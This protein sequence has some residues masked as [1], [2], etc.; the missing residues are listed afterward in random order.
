[1]PF[2]A[3]KLPSGLKI[4]HNGEVI[5]LAGANIGENL[6]NPSDNGNPQDNAR[7]AYGFGLTELN[8][9]QTAAFEDWKKKM[10]FKNGDSG[11][12]LTEPFAALENNS[13]MGPFKSRDEAVKE[14]ADLHT[15]VRTGTEGLDPEKEKDIEDAVDDGEKAPRVQR[16]KR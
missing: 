13:I 3:C 14:I 12:K 1:M 2:V 15:L 4:D 7:R 8:D 10:T 11:E 5:T 16:N 6:R 9:R